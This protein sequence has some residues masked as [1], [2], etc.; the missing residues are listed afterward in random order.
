MAQDA[1]LSAPPGAPHLGRG[2]RCLC[3]VTG[4]GAGALEPDQRA[5]RWWLRWR[6]LYWRAMLAAR[7]ALIFAAR[8]SRSWQASRREVPTTSTV[9]SRRVIW[10]RIDR[11]SV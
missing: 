10:A 1:G 9:G 3:D 2:Y 11:K 7:M 8:P 6:C 4:Q 5:R